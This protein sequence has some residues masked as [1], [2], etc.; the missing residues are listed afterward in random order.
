MT[1]RTCG[2]SCTAITMSSESEVHDLDHDD[3]IHESGQRGEEHK[4]DPFAPAPGT[5]HRK[6]QP[7]AFR[8]LTSAPPRLAAPQTR[9]TCKVSNNR[10]A[11]SPPS[12]AAT[13]RR[14]AG[15]RVRRR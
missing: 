11:P 9:G 1:A 7:S 14:H 4:R 8:P 5:F 6:A 13:P 3:D 2:R 10:I 12:A 15:D